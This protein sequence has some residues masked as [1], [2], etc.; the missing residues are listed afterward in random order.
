M[1]DLRRFVLD[2]SDH[3]DPRIRKRLEIGQFFNAY[4]AGED[5]SWIIGLGPVTDFLGMWNSASTEAA[6]L[7]IDILA[8]QQASRPDLE[9]PR[10]PVGMVSEY[11]VGI[12]RKKTKLSR[13]EKR[14]FTRT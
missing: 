12:A 10:L 13:F 1:S 8:K 5:G 6:E 7:L 2:V 11:G 3:C 4:E 9:E 14:Y